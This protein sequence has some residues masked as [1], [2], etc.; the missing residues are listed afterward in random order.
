[1]TKEEMTSRY[2]TAVASIKAEARRK[3]ASSYAAGGALLVWNTEGFHKAGNAA[4]FITLVLGIFS[5]FY[6]ASQV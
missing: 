5:A 6:L 1:M 3:E 4:K 2:E